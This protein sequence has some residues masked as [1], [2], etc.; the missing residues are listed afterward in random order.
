M[1]N[2]VPERKA[3]VGL[4]NLLYCSL[5]LKPPEVPWASQRLLGAESSAE[6]KWRMQWGIILAIACGSQSHVLGILKAFGPPMGKNWPDVVSLV[7][8]VVRDKS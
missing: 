4:L 8:A 2:L 6:A 1:L 3:V 5:A 7:G